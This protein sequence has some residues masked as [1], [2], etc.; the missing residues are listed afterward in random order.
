[1]K[2]VP[3]GSWRSPISSELIVTSSVG[4]SE[5]RPQG[6][7]LYWSEMRPLEGGRYVIVSRGSDGVTSDVTPRGFSART[8]VH[9]YGGGAFAVAGDTVW[10]SNYADQRLHRQLLGGKPEPITKPVDRRYADA[11]VDM[12]RGCLFAVRE[13]HTDSSR[14][15]RNTLVRLGLGGEDE[16]VIAEGAD[17]YSDPRLDPTGRHLCWLQWNHPH[18]PWDGT[19]LWVAELDEEGNLEHPARVPGE[20][21]DAIFQPQW[22][23]RGVL[24]F[25]SDRTGWWNLHRWHGEKV[26]PVLP[27]AAEF[28]SPQWVFGLSNY[29]FAGD[30][31]IVAA[32]VDSTGGHLGR[33]EGGKLVPLELPFTSFRYVRCSQGQV[34]CLA[35]SPT[36]PAQIISLAA[37]GGKA[38]TIRRSFDVSV[39]RSYFSIPQAIEFPTEGGRTAF[40][41]FYPPHNPDHQAP[42][43][44][45]PPLVVHSHGG[46]T[47]AFGTELN[48]SIQYWT[49][50]GIAVVEVNYGGSTGYGSEY[51]RRLEGQWG[52]VD[53]D[54][55]IN[56]AR[57]LIRRGQ[58][59]ARRVAISGGSA[60]G[61]TTLAALTMRDFF[62]AGADHFGL[63]DLVPFIHDTHKFESRYLESLI[64]PI[65]AGEELYRERSPLTHIDNLNCPLIV[66]QGLEDKVVPPNQSELIVAAARRKGL[67]VAYLQFKGEQHGFRQA[68]NIRMAM[69][70]ELDF[71]SQVF[72][73]A[74]AGDIQH[75]EIENL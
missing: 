39:D 42:E 52:V 65:E 51:R 36:E 75:V 72:D 38:E 25:V 27:M 7:A 63:S 74:L 14:E 3:F 18:M 55:C 67:P 44:E 17:F 62:R 40:A 13:D 29:A 43:G 31:V 19:Q 34:T 32:F 48:L 41:F 56:A 58:A 8:R 64:G 66:F 45:L 71:Y 15:A 69:D 5:V 6:E 68:K 46:P 70:G 16:R 11:V 59:D 53:V 24:H 57:D 1:M 35:A 30:D 60:G 2:A 9:E 33:V 10:F 54:D 20:E 22:S 73:F 37:A 50:R 21:A 12:R 28:G 26:E 49:S 4:L 23:P 61:Y 47:S